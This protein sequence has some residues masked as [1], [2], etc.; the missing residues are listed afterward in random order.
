VS[1]AFLG[2]SEFAATVLNALV[3]ANSSPRLVVSAPSRPKGRGLALVDPPV[4]V[5]AKLHGIEYFQPARM[6]DPVAVDRL[7][8]TAPTLLV[9]VA[10]GQILSRE[11]LELAPRGAV[12]LHGSILPKYRGPAPIA[13]AIENGDT[14]TGVTLQYMVREVDAGDIIAVAR[15]KIAPDDTHESLS[16][17]MSVLAAELLIEHLPALLAGR[18]ERTQQDP[19]AATRAPLLDKHEGRVDW[20]RPASRIH[21]HVRAMTPWPGASTEWT[22][23]RGGPQ[24]LVLRKTSVLPGTPGDAAPGT[25]VTAAGRLEVAT[26]QGILRIERL[27]RQGKSEMSAEEFLRGAKIEIGDRFQ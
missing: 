9:V 5:A 1:I 12:N 11:V 24:R 14:E 3:A 15:T 7:R 8:S 16:S 19:S 17:R 25:V 6:N 2:T 23:R 20:S 22:S 10:Y 18:S 13:R 27:L 4:V 21:D 26:G